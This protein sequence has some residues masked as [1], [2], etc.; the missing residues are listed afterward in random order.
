M[1]APHGCRRVCL[2]AHRR[3]R[4]RIAAVPR[5]PSHRAW[6]ALLA[7]IFACMVAF[8]GP[9]AGVVEDRNPRIVGGSYAA[10]SDW[11]FL[12]ALIRPGAGRPFE[13]QFCGGSVIAP[14]W[15]L[16]AAHCVVDSANQPIAPDR[17]AILTG[18]V[19]LAG[20][21]GAETPVT[22]V[23]V[24]PGYPAGPD[25]ALLRLALPTTAPAVALAR[26]GQPELWAAGTRAAVAG[27]GDTAEDAGVFPMAARQVSIPL[28][29]D[30][31][32]R[33]AIGSDFAATRELCAG[34]P[35]GKADSC[36]GDS[37]GPLA[38]RTR[39][40]PVL[41]G[42]VS[43]GYGC[44]RP[45]RPGLYTRV[46]AIGDWVT[47]VTGARPGGVVLPAPLI[48]VGA[49]RVVARRGK[50]VDL[51]Y[52]LFGSARRSSEYVAILDGNGRILSDYETA[53]GPFVAGRDLFYVRW[54]VPR[55][56]PS[57]LYF[58]VAA[59]PPKRDYGDPGCARIIVR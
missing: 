6:T 42:I 26:P 15:V 40:A 29:A 41:V 43:W 30:S 1:N 34:V 33:S 51:S 9:A 59:A 45:G 16:T 46:S 54:R 53:E 23:V 57:S 7:T 39:I 13:R 19:S 4:D 38:V 37:G 22:Q 11:P 58:C 32:C 25:A 48:R 21:S 17:V 18:T 20:G 5:R 10:Q 44:A 8:A 3:R 35:R 50:A 24:A 31:R 27:W 28:I 49:Q 55:S 14:D 12:V 2:R 52:R 56:A 36:Q 47:Q